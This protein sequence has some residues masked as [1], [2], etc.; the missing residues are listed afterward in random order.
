MVIVN[1]NKDK[2]T[3]SLNLEMEAITRQRGEFPN[4]TIEIEGYWILDR[5]YGI[6]LGRYKTEERAKEVLKLICQYYYD[7]QRLFEM[8][9][10]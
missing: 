8:P 2:T 9:E 7:E 5:K 4:L 3:E 1:Q 6:S 10:D